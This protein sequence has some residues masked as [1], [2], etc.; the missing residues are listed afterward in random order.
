MT[1]SPYPPQYVVYRD[2]S[3]LPQYRYVV[4]LWEGKGETYEPGPIWGVAVDD[5]GLGVLRH[6]L[7]QLGLYCLG[8]FEEDDPAILEV[9][10]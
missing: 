3:D 8:R 9:W 1:T 6:D 10:L 4:R 7:A 5:R 2:P